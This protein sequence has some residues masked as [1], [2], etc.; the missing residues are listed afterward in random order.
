[1]NCELRKDEIS[2]QSTQEG[3]E[4]K[5]TMKTKVMSNLG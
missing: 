2:K 5:K 3:T 1:M 4:K